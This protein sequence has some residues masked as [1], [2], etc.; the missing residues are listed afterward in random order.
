MEVV[1]P[2]DAL[3]TPPSAR[4]LLH[5]SVR[6]VDQAY[7][8]VKRWWLA[9]EGADVFAAIGT[10]TSLGS[11]QV[12]DGGSLT[13]ALTVTASVAA[14]QYIVAGVVGANAASESV[15]FSDSKGNAWA[16]DIQN[17]ATTTFCALGSAAVTTPLAS[18]VDTITAT[19]GASEAAR[20]IFAA[21]ISGIATSGAKDKTSSSTGTA[22]GWSSGATAAT[23]QND[24][25]VF[26]VCG[27]DSTAAE[28]STPGGS[29]TELIP[30]FSTSSALNMTIV[31]LIV[32]AGGTQT[33]TGT[34]T[35]SGTRA[36]TAVISTYRASAAAA[37]APWSPL[38]SPGMRGPS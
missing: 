3:W 17:A 27:D 29:Y 36:W 37:A 2:H 32:S 23:S 16:T 14:G 18:G 30:D 31:W 19:Y 24:E 12:F 1:L 8:R 28:T 35:N 11:A 38:R 26:A 5:G 25:L 15:T 6:E 34:W 10:P 13:Q 4:E 22:V 21:Q 7:R 33:A 20:M 9:R